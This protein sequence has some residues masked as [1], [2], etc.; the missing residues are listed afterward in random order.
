MRERAR[1]DAALYAAECRRQLTAAENELN[2]RKQA[3]ENCR[4]TQREMQIQMTDKSRGGIKSTEIVRY[5][6]HL[7]DLREREILLLDAVE[8]QKA[9]V[10]RAEQTVE[11]ALDKLGEAAK[12]TK[13]IE[14]H[15]ENWRR[16]IKIE[17]E[18]REQKSNDETGAILH[19]RQKFD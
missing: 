13:V 4:R 8:E 14:K 5:R 7:A 19:G 18:R 1:D 9:V 6:R 16:A 10:R 12:E 2:N 17:G 11:K 15:R 3:V